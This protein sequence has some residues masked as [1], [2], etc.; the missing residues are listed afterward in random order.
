MQFEDASWMNLKN[1]R[2][3]ESKFPLFNISQSL[4]FI[5]FFVTEVDHQ[6]NKFGKKDVFFKNCACV[7]TFHLHS[8]RTKLQIVLILL[9]LKLRLLY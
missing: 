7:I 1:W 9:P 5:R 6:I 8:L 2:I 3:V 4:T